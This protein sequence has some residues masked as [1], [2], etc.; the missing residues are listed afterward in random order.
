MNAVVKSQDARPPVV[1]GGKVAALVPHTLEEAFRVSQAI[2]ASGLAPKGI[3]KPE[4]IL[5][6]IMAG[7]EL[8]LAP[9]QALQSIAVINGRPSLWG[10]GLIAIVR[11]H[12]FKVKEWVDGDGDQMIARCEVT[13]PDNDEVTPGSF[14]VADA[15]KANLWGK[16]GPWQTYPRRM[17]QMRARAF[18]LRDGAADV[19]RGFSIREEVEDYQQIRD[20]TPQA[21]GMRARLE[22]R[23]P[24]GGFDAD[25]VTA[26]LD[27]ALDGDRI[28]DFDAQ[29][30]EI[31]DAQIDP[32]AVDELP[33]RDDTPP[34]DDFPGDRSAPGE[35]D[36]A[37]NP[38]VAG[39]DIDVI[40]WAA[41]FVRSLPGYAAVDPMREDWQAH[42][43]DLRTK[44]P[45][46][47]KEA[48]RAVADRAAEIAGA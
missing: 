46:L 3:D 19:L 23:T 42:K 22:A 45:A 41:A 30:G 35:P 38:G 25:H 32:P 24:V 39:G 17:L 1:A 14:S 12:G 2:A 18:A 13:R 40:A 20:V 31:I 28:P 21:T 29:T 34:A 15:K 47:F 4:Q 37:N 10:D 27:A 44:S 7:A 16:A 26:E 9:F 5:V 8:G 43:D 11:S 33:V 48:N 36:A 6:A